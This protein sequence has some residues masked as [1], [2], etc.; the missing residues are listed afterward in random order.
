MPLQRSLLRGLYRENYKE[1]PMSEVEINKGRL[2]LVSTLSNF[3][4]E[5]KD[6]IKYP[7]EGESEEV[8]FSDNFY[9]SHVLI[10]DFV[11]EVIKEDV[12][13]YDDIFNMSWDSNGDLHYLLK[14]YNGG[15]GFSE[16]IDTAYMNMVNKL[17]IGE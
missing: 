3:L 2:T 16:A 8:Q 10:G 7:C 6:Q 12:D 11:Y 15:C 9:D 17:K 1:K 4:K 5:H 13:F 14:Y